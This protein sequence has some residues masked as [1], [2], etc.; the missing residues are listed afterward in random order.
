MLTRL[1]K[2][3]HVMVGLIASL[4]FGHL[5][6]RGADLRAVVSTLSTIHIYHLVPIMM[7][8]LFAFILRAIRWKYLLTPVKVIPTHSLFAS[9]MIGFMANN[10]LPFRAGEIV[11][12]YSI[13]RS[14]NVSVSSSL[15]T[16][17]VE[18]LLDGITISLF[19]IV[20]LPLSLPSWLV[21]LNYFLL[22]LYSVGIGFSIWLIYTF[23]SKDSWDGRFVNLFKLP[24]NFH[25]KI[26]KVVF[27]FT[28]GLRILKDGK[29]VLWIS[30][31]S[32]AHWS[33]IALYY[34][35]L[36][37]AFGLSL[38]FMAA[39]T[40]LVVVTI[41]IM[42]PAAPGYVGNFQY[43]T[44]LALTF[45]SVPKEEALGF[46]L[47]AHAG[48]FIPVTAIGLLYLFRQSMGLSH[49]IIKEPK[50]TS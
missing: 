28:D 37:R 15:G 1:N 50:G 42:L 47:I 9:T 7:I 32:L 38:S 48:Q 46:S 30:I 31:L 36:F 8:L 6:F 40:V 44:V 17:I 14:E 18:R 29:Q 41:G 5:A 19:M 45:F 21:H 12:A 20:L 2:H 4:A 11:R 43:F 25:A 24:Q 26:E 33:V 10:L 49:L 34:F 39:I 22:F 35:L 3:I 16:L 13:A 23:A 27:N